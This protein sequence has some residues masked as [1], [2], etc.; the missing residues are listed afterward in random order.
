MHDR[1]THALAAATLALATLSVPAVAQEQTLDGYYQGTLVC[2]QIANATGILRAPLDMVVNGNSVI[3]ARPIFNLNGMRVLG[4]EIASG[5]LDGDTLHLISI[6][7]T[8]GAHYQAE[9]HGSI[10]GRGG[11]L[12]GTQT[13]MLPAGTRE[14]TC[15]AA[16][17][18]GRW[19]PQGTTGRGGSGAE[20]PPNE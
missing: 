20:E 8:Y 11:M 7:T 9:Y 3:F 4:S 14:R 1:S 6:G 18:K 15:V 13:W 16:F 2:E 12:T 19:Q 17:V 5:S 10:K